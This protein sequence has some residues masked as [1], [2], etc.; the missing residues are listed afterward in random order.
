MAKPDKPDDLKMISGIGP[1]IEAKLHGLGIYT[2]AQIAAWTEAESAWVAEHLAFR[3]RIEREDWVKQAA[4]LA[5]GGE[6]EY[7]R[8]FGK[9][10]R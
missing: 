8:V 5:K 3:G 4:A 1:G 10:P 9:E 6:A 7:V 2:W